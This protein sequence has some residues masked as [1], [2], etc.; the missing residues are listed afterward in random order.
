MTA[1]LIQGSTLISTSTSEENYHSLVVFPL[2][3]WWESRMFSSVRTFYHDATLW[4]LNPSLGL[5]GVTSNCIRQSD[6]PLSSPRC[7]M[8]LGPEKKYFAPWTHCRQNPLL[9]HWMSFHVRFMCLC[10]LQPEK[11]FMHSSPSFIKEV[12]W[13]HKMETGYLMVIVTRETA[14]NQSLL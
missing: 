3:A 8:H 2:P 7:K 11:V 9:F 5:N 1:P 12:I 10:F 13:I 6:P 4:S 14:T